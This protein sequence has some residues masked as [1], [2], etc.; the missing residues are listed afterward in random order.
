MASYP[1]LERTF[2]SKNVRRAATTCACRLGGP[3]RRC[4]H[5]RSDFCQHR[6]RSRSI[7]GMH[8]IFSPSRKHC[9][10]TVGVFIIAKSLIV[11]LPSMGMLQGKILFSSFDQIS[12][13]TRWCC[14]SFRAIRIS[15]NDRLV[16]SGPWAS[17]SFF[18]SCKHSMSSDF[19]VIIRQATLW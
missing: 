19:G 12:I 10:G 16:G 13:E 17:V 14:S 2:L 15:S 9:V 7:H 3:L 8:D 5:R 4:A 11:L 6:Q 1:T 18:D